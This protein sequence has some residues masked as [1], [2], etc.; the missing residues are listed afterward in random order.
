MTYRDEKVVKANG[1][2]VAVDV[3]YTH[4]RFQARVYYDLDVRGGDI[5]PVE[6]FLPN[7]GPSELRCIARS[8]HSA[9]DSWSKDWHATNDALKGDS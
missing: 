4:G 1:N 9:L 5:Q 8:L 3:D 6:L 7:I 2:G